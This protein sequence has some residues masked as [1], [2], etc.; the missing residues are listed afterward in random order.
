MMYICLHIVEQ[1]PAD[2]QLLKTVLLT[3]KMYNDSTTEVAV[4]VKR[5]I[6]EHRQHIFSFMGSITILK[7][8]NLN[9]TI[10]NNLCDASALF[11]YSWELISIVI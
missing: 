4:Q 5:T 7:I 1:N 11:F 8:S 3:T 6:S 10:L 9:T 2:K